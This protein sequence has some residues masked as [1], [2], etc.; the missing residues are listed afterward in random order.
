MIL[1]ICDKCGLAKPINPDVERVTNYVYRTVTLC[2][3]CQNALQKARR[4][5]EV[6]A[7]RVFL[8]GCKDLVMDNT[9]DGKALV[10][11]ESDPA[12]DKA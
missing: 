11:R 8:A 1:A 2:G 12:K 7:E 5:A 3:A 6:E 9:D 4:D 10:I